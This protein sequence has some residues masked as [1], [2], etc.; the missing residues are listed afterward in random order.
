MKSKPNR[1]KFKYDPSDLSKIYVYDEFEDKYYEA[2]CTDQSYS[3]DLNEYAHKIILKKTKQEEEQVDK[4]TLAATKAEIMKM[5][6]E[7]K[8]FSIRERKQAKRIEGK[9]SDKEFKGEENKEVEEIVTEIETADNS[10]VDVNKV[11]G[12]SANT[13][14]NIMDKELDIKDESGWSYEYVD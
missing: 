10:N 7:E 6:K 11:D 12:E 14:Q 13:G 9:G 2:L 5:I 3:K 1:V 4:K 8:D